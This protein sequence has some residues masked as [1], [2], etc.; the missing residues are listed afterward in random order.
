[1]VL[2][3]FA[4][5]AWGTLAFGAVYP[6]AY[7]PLLCGCIA[8]GAAGLLQSPAAPVARGVWLSLGLIAGAISLQI[9]P[10]PA[11]AL[12]WMSPATRTFLDNTDVNF[13][14]ARLAGLSAAMHIDAAAAQ[15]ARAFHPL[16]VDP[17][18]TMLALG[19]FLALGVFLVGTSRLLGRLERQRLTLALT[20]LG[21][22]LALVGLVQQ[23]AG[24]DRIYG[25]WRPAYTGISFASFVNR[26]HFAGWMLMVLPLSLGG[27]CATMA[28]TLPR[29]LTT[30]RE[31]LVWCSTA[32]ANQLLLIGFGL[33][34]MCVSLLVALSRSGIGCLALSLGVFAWFARRQTADASRRFVPAILGTLIVVGVAWVGADRLIDR[35]W[36]KTPVPYDARVEIWRRTARVIADFPLAGSGI[37][38]LESVMPRYAGADSAFHA[39]EAHNDYLELA[40]E[41][42]LLVTVPVLVLL[43]MFLWKVMRR[44]KGDVGRSG[45]WIR[46][47]ALA[48][49]VAI[50]A[51]ESVDFSLQLPANAAMFALC[52]AIGISRRG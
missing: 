27:A 32:D 5:V 9:V 40:A 39:L 50:L 4:V 33:M 16:S 44:L 18:A 26:N 30:W 19:M 13:L 7:W 8:V 31:R 28:R 10:L 3:V 43:A 37:A 51:Q 48:G 6:W 29:G 1:M 22:A 23:A 24:A 35:F 20:V 21:S 46:L 36:P 14:A 42:G 38:T 45:Y 47:G 12:A 41:G 49:I 17:R 11:T 2:P 15:R 25:L 34:L 52:C